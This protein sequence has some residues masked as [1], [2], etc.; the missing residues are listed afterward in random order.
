M[1][2]NNLSTPSLES[3]KTAKELLDIY[4]LDMRSA[5]LETAAAM[6]RIQR[7]E[8]GSGILNDPRMQQLNQGLEILKSRTEGRAERF[9]RLL[10]DPQD[11]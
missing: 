10:S 1:G 3:S 9:L 11:I 4:F 8:N 6:D 5:L 2:Q 7:A